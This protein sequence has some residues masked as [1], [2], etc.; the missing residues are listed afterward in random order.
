MAINR[1]H[2]IRS[3][4]RFHFL[5]LRK[6]RSDFTRVHDGYEIFCGTIHRAEMAD[7]SFGWPVELSSLLKSTSYGFWRLYHA[8]QARPPAQG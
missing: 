1:L 8:P 5:V 6:W 7:R 4:E 3:I 2:R